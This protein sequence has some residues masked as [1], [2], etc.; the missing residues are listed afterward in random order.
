M[1]STPPP[2]PDESYP[3][4]DRFGPAGSGWSRYGGAGGGQPWVGP[5]SDPLVPLDLRG[6][7]DR[8]VGVVQRSLMPLT[9]IQLVSGL[10]V[11]LVA[12]LALPAAPAGGSGGPTDLLP[13]AT[14]PA[15]PANPAQLP[16]PEITPGFFLGV[17]VM[18]ALTLLAQAASVYVALRDA[19][20]QPVTAENTLR[21]ALRRAPMLLLWEFAAVLLIMLG[22][23]LL[24]IPALYLGVVFGASLVGVVVVE[25]GSMTRC[26]TLV[27]RR[28]LP[29]A[30]RMLL[31]V[32]AAVL[33]QVVAG[34]V[35]RALSSP[36]SWTETLL[37]ALVS[38]PVGVI[39]TAV[40]LVTYAELR[41][42]EN[43]EVL[44]GT[45]A[46]EMDTPF[47]YRRPSL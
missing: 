46:T 8:I 22:L 16:L 6:W 24:F 26:F 9:L 14:S 39:G 37:N 44:T 35:V 38:V 28:F 18:L 15:T 40:V 30:G 21:F 17:L 3:R 20:G 27:N 41:G 10:G 12:H 31:V 29:T 1:A 36:G 4:P 42:R 34:F 19:A 25:R 7:F 5:L 43:Q 23:P 45:L 47:E 2:G 33:Y 32:A 13:L 11:S